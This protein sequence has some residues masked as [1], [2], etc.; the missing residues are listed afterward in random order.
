MNLTVDPRAVNQ[1]LS[2]LFM[3]FNTGQSAGTLSSSFGVE[4]MVAGDKSY[5]DSATVA[6]GWD[7][8]GGAI[9]PLFGT[10][11]LHLDLLS[12]GTSPTHTIIGLPDANNLYGDANPSIAGNGPHNPFF[13]ESATFVLNIPGLS[14]SSRV[15]NTTFQFN[16]SAGTYIGVPEPSSFA[17]LGLCFGCLGLRRSRNRHPMA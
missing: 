14:N 13:G 5:A 4:R 8:L 15:S 6:T 12:T 17:L 9:D 10:V 16:T 7:L 11:G 3:T 2:G 1:N